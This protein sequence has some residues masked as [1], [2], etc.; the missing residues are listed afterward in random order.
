M[1][2]TYKTPAEF[3][4]MSEY[5]KEKYLDQKS[6]HEKAEA[7]RVAKEAAK[8]AVEDALKD[9]DSKIADAEKR[10][11][12]DAEKE[13]ETKITAI[14]D[15][16]DR[17]LEEAEKAFKRVDDNNIYN[18]GKAVSEQVAEAL[19]GREADLKDLLTVKGKS[20]RLDNIDQTKATM[21]VPANG[22]APQ[23]APLVGP[24]HYNFYA[25][26][27]IPVYNTDSDTLR[28]VRYTYDETSDGIAVA[29]ENTLKKNFGY[30][31][32]TIVEPLKVIAGYLKVS[33]QLMRNVDGF[34]SWIGR[35]A[36]LAL[37]DEEDR[38]IYKGNG[39]TELNGLWT[40]SGV[41]PTIP[42]IGGSELEDVC[43]AITAIRE[44]KRNATAVVVSPAKWMQIYL[45][46]SVDNAYTYPVVFDTQRGVLTLGGVPVLYSAV[47]GREEG[48]IGDFNRGAAIWQNFGIELKYAEQNEDDFIRNLVTIRV[49]EMLNVAKYYDDGF[50]R[51]FET[52][53]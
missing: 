51:L 14:K 40:S 18:A 21:V 44:N 12:E 23:Y 25:R 36:V 48:L 34:A 53:T 1:T 16:Y 20:L 38:Q 7:E 17:K 35:E 27:I 13:A 43:S 37:R 19:K 32:E 6:Q 49:E 42:G 47:F 4:A 41:A 31:G 26:D 30:D 11:K 15:E 3:E 33:N 10:V 29:D 8:Q 45:N 24:G 5:Q 46:K 9:V 28:Y 52:T 22:V 39:T 50:Y 2:F